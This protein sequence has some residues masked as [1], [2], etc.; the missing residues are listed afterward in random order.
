MQIK[1][2][3]QH[4]YMQISNDDKF[5]TTKSVANVNELRKFVLVKGEYNDDEKYSEEK[6][7][8]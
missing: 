5:P 6:I 3:C 7:S 8:S 1:V 2:K 4:Q